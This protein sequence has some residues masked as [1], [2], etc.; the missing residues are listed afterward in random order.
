LLTDPSTLASTALSA[1]FSGAA[2][3]LRGMAA[4][5]FGNVAEEAVE[6]AGVGGILG[7]LL[8]GKGFFTEP[9]DV[10]NVGPYDPQDK[11]LESMDES[12]RQ[13]YS[14]VRAAAGAMQQPRSP[15]GR[16]LL[17]QEELPRRGR[18]PF[19]TQMPPKGLE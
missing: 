17:P 1:G 15:I 12:Q 5:L 4:P 2:R 10:G 9:M 13:A 19:M 3:G 16:S 7:G 6:E 8:G 14:S 18:R 11:A